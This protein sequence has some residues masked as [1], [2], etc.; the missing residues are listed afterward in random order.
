MSKNRWIKSI[1]EAAQ[2]PK[3]ELPIHRGHRAAAGLRIRTG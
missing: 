1:V 2:S 3:V